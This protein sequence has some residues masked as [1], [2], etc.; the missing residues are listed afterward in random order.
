M[1]MFGTAVGAAILAGGGMI[2]QQFASIVGTDENVSD[3]Y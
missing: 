1:L 2:Y 3:L